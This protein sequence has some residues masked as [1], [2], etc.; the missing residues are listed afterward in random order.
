MAYQAPH[1][2]NLRKGRYSE[3]GGFYFLTTSAA[4]R[5]R[6]FEETDRA[7]IVLDAILWLHAADRFIVDAAVVMPDHLH[8][9]GQLGDESR[10]DAAPT[11]QVRQEAVPTLAKVMHTL[12]S[13]S[14]KRLIGA[15]ATAPVW[16]DG[17]H[18]HGLRD[19]EDYRARVRYV[20]Q[21][22]VRAGLVRRVGDYPFIILP[23]WWH[24]D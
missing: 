4:G 18:D 7:R 9:V 20:V 13:Y 22:P 12:K 24:A 10:R 19:N 6:L 23:D 5:R 17:Y 21:N 8:L 15:G 3:V 1:S 2:R 14:A 11:N 16:Q